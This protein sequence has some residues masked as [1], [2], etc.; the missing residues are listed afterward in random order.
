M[1]IIQSGRAVPATLTF[2]PSV[3]TRPSRFVVVPA[4]SPYPAAGS[5]TWAC[6]DDAVTKVS[7]AMSERTPA[8]AR[9]ASEVSGK[10]EIGSQPSRIRQAS[11]PLAAA[12][13]ASVGVHAALA[14]GEPE[15]QCADHV[16][17]PERRQHLRIGDRIEHGGDGVHGEVSALG[18]VGLAG[19]DDDRARAELGGDGGIGERGGH[20]RRLLTA[21]VLHRLPRVPGQAGLDGRELDDLAAPLVGRVFEP[22]VE[23][24]AVLL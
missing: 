1:A 17:P 5:T 7:M 14:G 2:A 22:Q 19:D 9:L 12:S 24:R 3:L 10:S 20:C 15:L 21:A 23:H 18:Q 8:S 6:W 11:L 16:A 13:R 4:F